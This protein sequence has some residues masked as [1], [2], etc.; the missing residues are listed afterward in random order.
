[1]GEKGAKNTAAEAAAADLVEALEPIGD[2]ASKKMFGGYGVFADG[3]MFA[4]VDSSG[5]SYFRGDRADAEE[6]EGLGSEPHGK[7]PYW[8]VTDDE[9]AD[10]EALL[11]RAR[12]AFEIARAAKK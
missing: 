1:M 12:A 8:S 5:H 3:V 4:L 10:D 2:V 7:M 11:R 6:L 9:K